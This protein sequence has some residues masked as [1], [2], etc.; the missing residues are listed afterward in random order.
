MSIFKSLYSTDSTY[1][2]SKNGSSISLPEFSNVEFSK[3]ILKESKNEQIRDEEILGG[4][5][6]NNFEGYSLIN[7]NKILIP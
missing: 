5:S 4:G 1:Q 2:I 6:V 7:S 3:E